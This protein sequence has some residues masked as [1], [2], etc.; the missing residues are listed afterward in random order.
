METKLDFPSFALFF[1]PPRSSAGAETTQ[2]TQI[3]ERLKEK[4]DD[5]KKVF[6]S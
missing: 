1:Q 4:M 2:M 3:A 6:F 5:D